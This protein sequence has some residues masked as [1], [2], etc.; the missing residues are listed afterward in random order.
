MT[1]TAKAASNGSTTAASRT[2][3][4]REHG[5]RRVKEQEAYH[6]ATL[7]HTAAYE[8]EQLCDQIYR[9]ASDNY[10]WDGSGQL[11]KV[12]ADQATQAKVRDAI[13][14]LVVAVDHLMTLA[15]DPLS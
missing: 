10:Q 1:T 6:L 9:T 15:A 5:M 7:I 14:C 4:E 2:V 13:N 8:A 11:A 3:S 12:L